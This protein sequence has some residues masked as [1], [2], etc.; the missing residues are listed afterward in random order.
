[1]LIVIIQKGSESMAVPTLPQLISWINTGVLVVIAAI[2]LWAVIVYVNKLL[3]ILNSIKINS[4]KSS[5]VLENNTRAF[6]ELSRTNDNMTRALELLTETL[7]HTADITVRHESE[8]NR[9]FERAFTML[10]NHTDS[11]DELRKEVSS[12]RE[13]VNTSLELQK[14]R[15]PYYKTE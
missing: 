14:A 8:A 2:F 12:V 13:T 11:I 4:D 9:N 10:D 5:V 15:A 3:P 7:R 6:T 1:M